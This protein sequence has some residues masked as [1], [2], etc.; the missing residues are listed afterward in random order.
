MNIHQIGSA[1]NEYVSV[2]LERRELEAAIGALLALDLSRGH[3]HPA[4]TSALS[5]L[6]SQLKDYETKAA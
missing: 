6:R 1:R 2:V 4:I 3:D 5:T